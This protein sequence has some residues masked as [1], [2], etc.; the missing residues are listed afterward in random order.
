MSLN[1]KALQNGSDIR[2]VA[3]EG[4]E[5]EE[6]NFTNE[7]AQILGSA[8]VVWLSATRKRPTEKLVVA[9]GRDSRLSGTDLKSAV[10]DGLNQMGCM[11]IDCARASTPA[12]YMTTIEEEFVYDGA[13]MITASHL[14][15]NR[16]GMKFFTSEGGLEKSDISEV[17]TIAEKGNFSFKPTGLRSKIDFMSVYSSLL[18]EKIRNEVNSKMNHA[19]PLQGFKILVDAGNG[20]GGFFVD[21]VL[22]HLGAD[23]T[24]S[25]FLEPD[26][27]FPNHVPNP[28]DPDAIKYIQEA[29][30]ANHA[31]LGIIFDTDVDRA[32]VVDST[33]SL[34]NRNRLVALA[35]AIV[36]EEHP[37]SCI[38]TDSITSD[39]LTWF[40]EKKLKGV[41]C[42]FK[43]GYKNVINEAIRLNKEN[44]ECWLAI[45]TSGHAALKENY[46][47]DDGA[48]LVAKILI[49]A[50][51]LR[52]QNLSI[53]DLI[54]EMPEPSESCE[55]RLKI[56][57][58]DFKSYGNRIIE[59]L[60]KF[61]AKVEGWEIA[62]NNHE[63]IRI[64]CNK[65]HG[66]GW[67]LLRLSLH[68]PIIP[69][70]IESEVTGGI[71]SIANK[72]YEFLTQFDSLDLSSL[73]KFLKDSNNII[74]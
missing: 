47:L 42:R 38:V 23:S 3:M 22:R 8:F 59:D 32:A 69:I 24:G 50:A 16:N 4:I 15:F 2:G 74:Y 31:D 56:N 27:N 12:M 5:G 72:L 11:A 20:V 37:G 26:G 36:L 10:M 46:F 71:A 62:P 1:L 43:R 28:E 44:Q 48:Y 13:I 64:S 25:L 67:F 66:N 60:R 30:I 18:V 51:K 70:N 40:I 33:G 52:Q 73:S 54:I 41:H 63:G 7:T 21:K 35:S 29:V 17:I 19:A 9:V 53:L 65:E 49:K 61:A 57:S 34:I 58:E 6:V 68:D 45:E 39:G 55:F 14:P